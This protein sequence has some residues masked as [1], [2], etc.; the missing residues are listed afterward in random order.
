MAPI[1]PSGHRYFASMPTRSEHCSTLRS[2]RCC[3][4]CTWRTCTRLDTA[5]LGSFVF[6][7]Q[8]AVRCTSC[9]RST[10]CLKLWPPRRLELDCPKRCR[11]WGSWQ[12]MGWEPYTAE[13]R[14]PNLEATLS[15]HSQKE[16]LDVFLFDQHTQFER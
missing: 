3:R 10:S 6:A 13:W 2:N 4:T 7:A 9:C 5:N 1:R 14:K 15:G 12:S 8:L 16:P 11:A